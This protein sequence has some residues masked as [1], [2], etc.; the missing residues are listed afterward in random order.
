M[1]RVQGSKAVEEK[2]ETSQRLRAKELNLFRNAK[3][4]TWIY[5]NSFDNNN[6]RWRDNN[7]YNGKMLGQV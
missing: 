3:W 1:D 6:A 7:K 2:E 4:R 5:N